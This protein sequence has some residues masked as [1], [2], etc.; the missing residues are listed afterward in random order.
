V[1][2]P[3]NIL[4][5]FSFLISLFVTAQSRKNQFH[6]NAES[7]Q[8]ALHVSFYSD[9]VLKD[10]EAMFFHKHYIKIFVLSH[11]LFAIVSF[12]YW[13]YGMLI[14]A[15]I[16]FHTFSLTT[17]VNHIEKFGYKSFKTTDDSV[18]CPWIWPLALGEAWH[19]NHHHDPKSPK[20]GK[21]WWEVDPT[22]WLIKLIRTDKAVN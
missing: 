7:N 21:Q 10:K 3:K 9:V 5:I 14:P 13:L 2:P 4:F 1:P 17:S 16:A 8:H 22:F 19:N 18:N 6:L 20:Y 15:L 11:L 12:P